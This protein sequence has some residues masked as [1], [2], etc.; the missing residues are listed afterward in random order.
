MAKTKTMDLPIEGM[1]CASCAV[2]IEKSLNNV[3]GIDE[4]SVDL[5]SE[6]AHVVMDS[7]KVS[8]DDIDKT[9]SGLGYKVRTDEV[10]L[11]THGMH[12]ASCVLTIEKGLMRMDGVFKVH[13]DLTTGI[14]TVEYDHNQISVDEINIHRLAPL[15]VVKQIAEFNLRCSVRA[16]SLVHLY[17]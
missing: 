17:V 6:K 16:C 4:A 11:R 3:E 12:C 15:L 2:S 5:N 8:I 9:V 1:H 10:K 14:V 13:A 7:K